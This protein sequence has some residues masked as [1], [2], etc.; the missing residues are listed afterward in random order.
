M[1]RIT[2]PIVGL[3][4][5]ATLL[6]INGAKAE[7]P[8]KIDSFA[9]CLSKEQNL[10]VLML[11]D[12]S[13]SLRELK[14]NRKAR[15][16]NDVNDDRVA[17][18]KSV[19]SV[20]QSSLAATENSTSG[21]GNAE[22]SVR[23]SVAGFGDKYRS[24]LPFT[25]L[26]ESNLDTINSVLD[27]QRNHDNDL[28]TRYHKALEGAQRAFKN[29]G[30]KGSCRLLMW[31]SDGQHDNDNIVGFSK[32]EMNQIQNDVCGVGGVVDQLR[33]DGVYIVA[34]GLNPE[35]RQLGLMQMIAQGGAAYKSNGF[36][37][38]KSASFVN[39]TQCG[40]TEPF[41]TFETASDAE[42]IVEALFR[43][44]RNVPGIPGDQ[45][46]TSSTPLPV[47]V[48]EPE[49]DK[50]CQG[51]GFRADGT[52][53][54]FNILVSRPNKDVTVTVV[55]PDKSK[56]I[57]INEA[58][59][60]SDF[61]SDI[62]KI[63]PVTA[64]KALISAHQ[65]RTNNLSGNWYVSF[66]GK[67]VAGSTGYVSFVG[68]ADVQ[69]TQPLKK[70]GVV[71]INRNDAV[72]MSF[73]VKSKDQISSIQKLLV[74]FVAGKS[75]EKVDAIRQ[76]DGSFVID[77]DSV[78]RV[79]KSAQFSS[80]SNVEVQVEPQG[81]ID[82][83]TILRSE[84]NNFNDEPVQAKFSQIQFQ[85][86][87]RNGAGFPV[88]YNYAGPE[89]RIKGTPSTE[90][91]IT[92]RGPDSGNGSIAFGSFDENK[93]SFEVIAPKE[94]EISE[95]EDKVCDLTIKPNVE[96][97]DR[98][99]LSLG[100]TYIDDAGKTEKAE[101][102]IPIVTEKETDIG[103]GIW[104]AIK[105]LI[106][107][108]AIQGLVRLAISFLVARFSKLASD[109]RTAKL[110]AVIDRTGSIRLVNTSSVA[111]SSNETFAY[112]NSSSVAVFNLFAEYKFAASPW[113]L[114][115]RSTSRPLGSV[116]RPG[117]VIIG[118]GGHR[119]IKKSTGEVC[120]QVEL[121]LR[122]QWI[123]ALKTE[124]LTG[125]ANGLSE[126]GAEVVVFL[127]PYEVT[128]FENQIDQLE[129]SINLGNFPGQLTALVDSAI[130]LDETPEP[131]Q[132][133]TGGGSQVDV[134]TGSTSQPDVFD[135]IFDTNASVSAQP[136]VAATEKK[137]KQPRRKKKQSN[138]E[139]E[140]VEPGT[141]PNPGDWDLFN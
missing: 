31:F 77:S 21:G 136:S 51:F 131:P 67:N 140:N 112:N 70:N 35:P 11:V 82:G 89:I 132:V 69:M 125:L 4:L 124:S 53:Q 106:F 71:E 56:R 102:A 110:E 29:D 78:T 80:A 134:G 15:P 36:S 60:P 76:E 16:G 12:E 52:I 93:G 88:C 123:V 114:F 59:M 46:D 84:G 61:P 57:V 103:N 43:A 22:L 111:G 39:V 58:G 30:K 65:S 66:K 128:S 24:R 91:K 98:T 129:S 26:N 97:F 5:A 139:T 27:D 64:N 95:K 138:G 100:V 18:L 99:E 34:A 122:K 41:G 130:S 37:K 81:Q 92:C 28:H 137:S 1:K 23:I 62:I 133:V 42:K 38:N 135:N 83:L 109:A 73:R 14:V 49:N 6:P 63:T 108:L 47:D 9:Q 120:G 25:D 74:S 2:A 13:K 105:L 141:N 44:L 20:L 126:V 115:F 79:L 113:R 3:F 8:T 17:A 87:V 118:S 116:S 94:C 7:K 10:D 107:F 33:T 48:C 40:E 72:P 68:V 54:S 50:V 96:T 86:A 90:L 45:V 32:S 127:D 55:L 19:V 75:V 119:N 101:V 85:I 117:F 121:S 104:A